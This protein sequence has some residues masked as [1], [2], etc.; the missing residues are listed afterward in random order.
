MI[1]V[2]KFV[3]D[4]NP[5]RCSG[6]D[7]TAIFLP[8]GVEQIRLYQKNLNGTL[9]DSG[10]FENSDVV[11]AHNAPGYH[12]EFSS[13]DKKFSFSESVDCSLYGSPVTKAFI[14]V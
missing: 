14:Y 6:E 12:L 11:I 4:I 9:L 8:G 2:P 13:P 3:M 7:C 1:G 5:I 10:I